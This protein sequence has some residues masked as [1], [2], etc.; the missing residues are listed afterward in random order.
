MRI[1][2]TKKHIGIGCPGDTRACPIWWALRDALGAYGPAASMSVGVGPDVVMLDGRFFRLPP[3]VTEFI[4]RFDNL[5]LV[6]PLA[7]ELPID[8][9]LEELRCSRSSSSS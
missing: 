7:F 2:V 6:G 8:E 9:F 3:E 4:Y 5:H 1:E